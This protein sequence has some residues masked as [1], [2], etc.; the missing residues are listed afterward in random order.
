MTS[1]KI[2]FSYLYIDDHDRNLNQVLS[3]SEALLVP[4]KHLPRQRGRGF[5]WFMLD[6][7]KMLVCAHV[8]GK[9]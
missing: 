8:A 1:K 9:R 3:R 4:L 2:A 7:G 6:G 5:C